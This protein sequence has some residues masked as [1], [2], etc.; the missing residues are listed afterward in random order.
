MTV[1]AKKMPPLEVLH[2]MF[3]LDAENGRLIRKQNF[4]RFRA[5]EVAGTRMADGHLQMGIMRKR[6]L[7]HRVIYYMATGVDPEDMVV[8]HING[9]PADNRIENLRLATVSQNSRSR[10][11][12]RS[13][14]ASGESN[15][16]WNTYWQRWQV[17]IGV[18]GKRVQRKFASKEAA[19]EC[20]RRL[21]KEMFGEFAGTVI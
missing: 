20:A 15:V 12:N 11:K 17:S 10:H 19:V 8:D 13:D 5:G 6:Y 2:D 7:V 1:K 21:R 4:N 18:N 3:V 9:D 16:S 14:N